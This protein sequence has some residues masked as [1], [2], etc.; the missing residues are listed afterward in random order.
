MAGGE[1]LTPDSPQSAVTEAPARRGLSARRLAWLLAALT[2]AVVLGHLIAIEW[3]ARHAPGSQGLATLPEPMFTR[4]LAPSEEEP[5][6]VVAPPPAPPPPAPVR[7][8]AI[9]A[10]APAPAAS[11]TATPESLASAPEPPPTLAKD[12][13]PAPAARPEPAAAAAPASAPVAAASA[14]GPSNGVLDGVVNGSAHGVTNGAGTRVESGVAS[15]APTSPTSAPAP[16]SATPT[17]PLAA[18]WPVDTR[19]TYQLKGVF[20][21][22]PLYGSARVQWLRQGAQYQARVEISIIPFGSATYTSQGQ[23]T[24]TGLVP[25]AFEDARGSRRRLTRITDKEVVMHDG[26]TFERP[27]GVQDMAS[28][29]IELGFRLRTGQASTDL[30]STLSLPLVRPGA[31]DTWTYDVFAR[32]LLRTPRLGELDTVRVTPRPFTNARGTLASEIWF[33]PRLQYLPVRFKVSFGEEAA[34]DLVVE[35]IEQR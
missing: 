11:A 34:L 24:P 3:L 2:V 28:Q 4:V 25:Q 12:E 6:V 30:G 10:A 7:Q 14:A 17:D 19:V 15:A 16:A 29:F 33:A 18:L 35:T 9:V 32:E 8:E 21:G 5:P 27:P 13:P 22:G 1:G 26:R 31:V 20:R 23:I